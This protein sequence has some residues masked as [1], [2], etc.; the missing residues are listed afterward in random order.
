[1]NIQNFSE[2]VPYKVLPYMVLLD[3]Q[4]SSVGYVRQWSRPRLRPERN[5]GYAFQWFAMA[6]AVVVT[7]I[8]LGLRRRQK[9]LRS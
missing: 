8:A 6:L 4:Q 1:M 3:P 7:Y 2:R 9:L 5:R